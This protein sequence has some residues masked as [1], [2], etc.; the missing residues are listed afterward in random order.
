MWQA[1]GTPVNEQAF[2]LT[3]ERR[4]LTAEASLP[5]A[6]PHVLI[7]LGP[8]EPEKV[9]HGYVQFKH[10]ILGNWER[11]LCCCLHFFFLVPSISVSI[12]PLHPQIPMLAKRAITTEP[13]S[14]PTHPLPL[15]TLV[16]V[17][18]RLACGTRRSPLI[19]LSRSQTHILNSYYSW[20]FLPSLH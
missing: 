13:S 16:F 6:P 15:L 12:E 9:M 18:L 7:L 10:P 20:A 2:L 4:N 1:L 17:L 5:Q 3:S 8:S 14:V 11:G 19:T